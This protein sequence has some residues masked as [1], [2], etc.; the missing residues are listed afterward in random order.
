MDHF[1]AALFHDLIDDTTERGDYTDYPANYIVG[2]SKTCEV[3]VTFFGIPRWDDRDD[4]SN[5][6][7]CLEEVVDEDEHEDNFPGVT[8]PSDARYNA[9][10]RAR[11]RHHPRD[12]QLLPYWTNSS[13]GSTH[14]ESGRSARLSA[15]LRTAARR[16]S[17][18]A[19]CS[20]KWSAPAP[21][22]R[23]M[24]YPP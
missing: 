24:C 16:S 1:F 17:C 6:V 8:T 19:T 5:Y 20:R 10:A 13:T 7:W 15:S 23:I 3:R 9:G 22:S 12:A 11:V 18:R 4:V 2:V 14:G 21:M